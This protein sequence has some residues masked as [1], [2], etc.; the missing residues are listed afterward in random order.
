MFQLPVDIFHKPERHRQA[1]W[2]LRM[3]RLD[4][5]GVSGVPAVAGYFRRAN[6]RQLYKAAH[7]ARQ[8]GGESQTRKAGAIFNNNDFGAGRAEV[9][10]LNLDLYQIMP[11]NDHA[12]K[13]PGDDFL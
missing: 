10:K 8:E 12:G 9:P 13:I 11:R 1:G 4:L 3:R 6:C 2:T 5:P 7:A